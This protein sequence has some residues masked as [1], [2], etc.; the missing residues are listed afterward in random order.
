MKKENTKSLPKWVPNRFDELA[1]NTPYKNYK[2]VLMRIEAAEL[3]DLV[4]SMGDRIVKSIKK[5]DILPE[6]KLKKKLRRLVKCLADPINQE[7]DIFKIQKELA[8]DYKIISNSYKKGGKE[9]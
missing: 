8:Y 4:I 7:E 3:R 5:G 6:D 2:S 9:K 1:A